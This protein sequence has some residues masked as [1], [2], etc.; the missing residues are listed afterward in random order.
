MKTYAIK[1]ELLSPDE[2][3]LLASLGAQLHTVGITFDRVLNPAQMGTVGQILFDLKKRTGEEE[4]HILFAI[5]DWLNTAEDWFGKISLY[6]E[7][8]AQEASTQTN[9]DVIT[10][11]DEMIR[12]FQRHPNELYSMS[13]RH[14]EELVAAMLKDLGYSIELTAKGADGGVD[15]FATQK[16]EVGESLIIVDCKRYSADKH[17]G[18]GVV[19]G[20]YGIAEK[21]GATMAMIATTSFF[22]RSAKEFKEDVKYRLALRDYHDLV[23]WL[24]KYD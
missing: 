3:V 16:S 9:A 15:I 19:R 2:R 20:L 13:P 11:D 12:Y 4:N 18:V 24:K 10:I 17:V 14:F 22:T 21:M 5:G 23:S 1:M 8:R 7:S 6:T